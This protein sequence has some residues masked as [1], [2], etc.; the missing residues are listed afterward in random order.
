MCCLKF[1]GGQ[2]VFTINEYSN[3]RC[4]IGKFNKRMQIIGTSARYFLEVAR[5]GSVT[6]AAAQLHVVVSAVSRQIAKLE[7]SIGCPLFER[8]ARG[9]V[10]SDAGER[11][12]AH[13][14]MVAH[15][16]ER[17]VD[18][19]RRLGGMKA[20]HLRLACSEGLGN[21]FM[22]DA[23]SSYAQVNT[24]A[25]FHLQV[26]TPERM[27]RAL[28]RG[29]VDMIA[30]FAIAPVQGLRIEYQQAAPIMALVAP[31][32]P[33]AKKKKLR[34]DEIVRHRLALPEQEKTVRQVLDLACSLRGLQYSPTYVANF[35]TLL[36]LA[37]NAGMLCLS[38]AVSAHSFLR[39]GTL[40]QIPV[41]DAAFRQRQLQVLT[42]EGRTLAPYLA[43]FRDHL[44]ACIQ[45][46]A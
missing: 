7:E 4:E 1:Y 32:H 28:V 33:L 21:G 10:L 11:L 6:Q 35:A 34:V 25:T 9:M 24:E 31:E 26:D 3:K 37:S 17:I 2:R 45:E 22:A 13:M 5:T 44:V 19:V 39:S 43:S 38:A 14:R 16:S 20:R 42:L 30:K 40:V 29:E 46:F 12:A 41:D 27:S 36:K 15:D 23:M 18:E 8:H